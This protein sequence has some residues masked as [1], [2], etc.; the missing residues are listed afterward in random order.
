MKSYLSIG[1]ACLVSLVASIQPARAGLL[2]LPDIPLYVRVTSVPNVFFQIDDSGSMDAESLTGTH[3]TLCAYNPAHDDACTEVWSDFMYMWTGRS[4]GEE[5]EGDSYNAYAFYLIKFTDN[6]FSG[7]CASTNVG[8]TYDQ[9]SHNPLDDDWR[10]ISHD[11]NAMYFDPSLTYKP[12]PNFSNA[13]FS[14]VR[15]NPQSGT[16]GYNQTANLGTHQIFG[17]TAGFVFAHWL[18][19][20]GF[21]GDAPE[22]NPTNYT[23]IGNGIVDGW[24]SHIRVRVTGSGFTCEKYTAAPTNSSLNF[25]SQT[26]SSS[27]CTAATKG[28]SLAELQQNIANWFQYYR[29]RSLTA[30]AAVTG[31]IT[32]NQELRYG[33]S[34]I[35]HSNDLFETIPNTQINDYTA[36]N[37]TLITNFLNYDWRS[38]GTPL[39]RGLETVG[40]YFAGDLSGKPSPIIQSCQKNFALLMTDGFWNGSDPSGVSTDEDGD[41]GD[42]TGDGNVD[43]SLAD[44]ARHYYDTDLN[45]N[46][47][48]NVGTDSFDTNARQHMVTYGV[49]FGVTGS[50]EDRDGDGWPE[51]SEGTPLGISDK[52]YTPSSV[53]NER[54]VDDLWHASYNSRGRFI[55]ASNPDQVVSALQEVIDSINDRVGSAAAGAANSGSLNSGSRIFQAKFDS[56]DWHGELLSIPINSDGSLD[57]PEWEANA[58]LNAK[59]ASFFGQNGARKV[60]SYRPDTNAGIDFKW[61]S[62]SDGQKALLNDNPLTDTVD[63]DGNGEARLE[64]VRGVATNENAGLF[65]RSRD[66]KLGD[67]AHSNPEFIGAPKFFYPFDNYESFFTTHKN[68]GGVVYVGSNDGMLHAFNEANGEELFAFVPNEVMKNLGK[69]SLSNYSHE[70]FVDGP[71]EYGDVRINSNW[72]SVIAGALRSGGQGLF[73]L[74]VTSPTSFTA[75]NVLWE[76]TDED[77][78]DLGYTFGHPQVKRMANGKWAVIIGNGLNATEA[79]GHAS[80]T[81]KASVFILFIEDGV[82]GWATSDYVKLTVNSGSV[83]SPNAILTPTAAD[84]NGDAKVDYIYAGDTNGNMW[85]FDVSDS[86]P[87]SWGVAFSGQPLYVALN[88]SGNR[89]P[90]TSRPAIRRH[91]Q[92][93]ANGVLVVFGTGK[94]LEASDSVS[95]GATQS[96]YAIWDRDGNLSNNTGDH[97]FNRSQ[98][99]SSTLSVQSGVRLISSANTIEWFDQDGNPSKRGWLIDLPESGERVVQQ[100]VIRDDLAFLVS[101]TPSGSPCSAGGTGWIMVFDIRTGSAPTFAVLD[102]NNDGLFNDSDFAQVGSPGDTTPVAPVGVS[103]PSIPN[104]PVFVYD[105][106]QRDTNSNPVDTFPPAPNGRRACMGESG[107]RAYT[108]TTQANSTILSVATQPEAISCGRQSWRQT[109]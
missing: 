59:S 60:V 81:G 49:A 41:G 68:R 51:K 9:C 4:G 29:K 46:M 32:D 76:F 93:F 11:F 40:E 97:G 37:S 18:D 6:A 45:T 5:E 103:V 26:A 70:F 48:N 16:T 64:Y 22:A 21:S 13:T 30:R 99:A 65:F 56:G 15:S 25:T 63:D 55:S 107:S 94:Y 109:R 53:A 47:D 105:D 20:K 23:A 50:V 98:L 31:V 83:S 14:A 10:F 12:W 77:D 87:A 42:I 39:R 2:D 33:L 101:L 71:L 88:A 85:K 95:G 82:D 36:R 1:L 19:D 75:S 35:N 73:A 80:T 102:I 62:L 8:G 108:Y 7:T 34:V 86:D 66:N 61:A 58:I 104:L 106:Q 78:A 69:L 54:K 17:T 67:M 57:N 90:I 100:P 72:K 92:G 84:I 28:Q 38:G 52:W 27:E 74:D 3:F 43:V 79:D 44:V 96:V 24:D 89:Q 91:P